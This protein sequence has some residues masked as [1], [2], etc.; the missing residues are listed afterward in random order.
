MQR[1]VM[2]RCG[3]GRSR[4]PSDQNGSQK[5]TKLAQH[6]DAENPDDEDIGAICA[7]LECE[8]ITQ[9]H[10]DQDADQSRYRERLRAAAIDM[11]SD[12][13]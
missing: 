9:H 7:Q 1:H 5:R 2:A 3:D 12:G 11:L 4:S 13:R 10:A 6:A 8:Q